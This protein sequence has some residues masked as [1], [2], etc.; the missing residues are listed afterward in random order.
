MPST[1]DNEVKYQSDVA[2]R[3]QQT[4]DDK[5]TETLD[6]VLKSAKLII[7]S[8]QHKGARDG[9]DD[10]RRCERAY[11]A[12]LGYYF[13][14]GYTLFALG[15]V[16]ELWECHPSSVIKSYPRTL[17]LEAAFHKEGRY[18]RFWGNHDDLWGYKDA[19]TKHLSAIY[20]RDLRVREALKLNVMDENN[21]LG[22]IFLVHGH[23]GTTFSDKHSWISRPVV[24]YLWRNW[25]RFTKRP[26]TTPA[27]DYRLRG[28][29]DVA[30][31]NWANS[32]TGLILIAGHTHRPVFGSRT[33]V[34]RVEAELNELRTHSDADLKRIS[35]L[36]AELEFVK[37]A[38][39]QGG[40]K[41]VDMSKPCYFNTG[42]CSFGD[43][44]VTGIEITDGEIKLV[45]WPNDNDRPLPQFLSKDSLKAV[46]TAVN[47][48]QSASTPIAVPTATT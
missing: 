19:V 35:E 45:R 20:G 30:M 18:R 21:K 10:F 42:C 24:R 41:S 12:A 37:A 25:Q 6:L 2:K 26:S 11:N 5:K 14:K 43:G 13:E 38:E 44:D 23:Q 40:D 39:N 47:L 32:K 31:Y 27:T 34:G 33:H 1:K 8:D 16:E 48:S 29:H 17:E 3:L 9:A 4:Y 15:D 36:R 22:E 46:L 7:F 28:Q